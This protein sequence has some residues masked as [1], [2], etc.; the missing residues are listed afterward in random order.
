MRVFNRY[1]SVYDF[2]LVL[3]DIV[4]IFLSTVAVRA[5]VSSG[6]GRGFA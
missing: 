5:A 6:S 2:I 3:G 4:V 1:F